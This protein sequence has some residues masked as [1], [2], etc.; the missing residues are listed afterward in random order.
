VNSRAIRKSRTYFEARIEFTRVLEQQKTLIQK[1]EAEIRTKKADYTRSLRQLEQISERIHA[2]RR[3]AGTATAADSARQQ[4][5][6]HTEL[7]F[8]DAISAAP[9]VLEQ[10]CDAPAG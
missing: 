5:S 1:L 9:A 2:E 8:A 7:V 6:S 4:H 10:V 3:L